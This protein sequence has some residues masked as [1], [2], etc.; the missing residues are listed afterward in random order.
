[1][2][3][4]TYSNEDMVVRKGKVFESG[5]YEDKNFNLTPDEMREA[6]LDFKPVPIDIEHVPSILDSK[7]GTLRLIEMSGDGKSL[8]GEVSIPK[9]L[10][11]VTKGAALKVSATWNRQTKKLV[12]LALVREPRVSDAILMSA[13]TAFADSESEAQTRFVGKR[14]NSGDVATIQKM[15]DHA[16]EL[17]AECKGE[18]EAQ[19]QGTFNYS[20]ANLDTH[21]NTNN[22]K[23]T[24]TLTEVQKL[25]PENTNTNTNPAANAEQDVTKVNAQFAAMQAENESMK[26]QMARILAASRHDKAIIFAEEVI[27]ANKVFPA[28]KDAIVALFEQAAMDD[29]TIE[30][31]PEALASFGVTK[32]QVSRTVA[33]RSLFNEL[34]AHSLTEERVSVNRSN[35]FNE[36][37]VVALFDRENPKTEEEKKKQPM[38]EE[39]KLTLLGATPLGQSIAARS[40]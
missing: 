36:T 20:T 2:D 38:S 12:G 29:E 7:L 39:R 10:H 35:E 11:D 31:K 27:K 1:M 9:W 23:N 25:M 32:V 17:G 13:F 26:K 22:N 30:A 33:L 24:L 3:L 18:G 5:F 19:E 6:I 15:H 21:N 4:V 16:V 28:A 37:G 8:L 34:P 14:N 40:K